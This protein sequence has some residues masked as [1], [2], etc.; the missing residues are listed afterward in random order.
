MM[1]CAIPRRSSRTT[2]WCWSPRKTERWLH[3]GP[4]ELAIRGAAYYANL[5]G[6]PTVANTA[7][8]LVTMPE[9][10]R[11]MLPSSGGWFLSHRNGLEPQERR[12]VID[13]PDQRV[14]RALEP[15]TVLSY[16]RSRGWERKRDFGAGA[17]VFGISIDGVEHELL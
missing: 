17:A 7:S 2:L 11:L 4:S 15:R 10:Q 3:V 1:T 16:L 8:R 12:M 6:L 14:I 9:S 5:F 13:R